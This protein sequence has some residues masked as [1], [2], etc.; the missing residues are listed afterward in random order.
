MKPLLSG[1][2]QR[3]QEKTKFVCTAAPEAMGVKAAPDKTK[4]KLSV[5]RVGDMRMRKETD[6]SRI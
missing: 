3:S 5:L 6:Y 2:V 4:V 1:F